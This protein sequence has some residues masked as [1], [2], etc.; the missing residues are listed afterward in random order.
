MKGYKGMNADM[1]CR[2]MQFEVG[3][4]YHVDGKI[5]VCHNG[6]HFCKNLSDV[7]GY[8]HRYLN[9]NRF[10]IVDVSGTIKTDGNKSAASDMEIIRELN[11]IE[12]NRVV[13][14]NGYGCGYGCDGNGY[15][16]GKGYGYDND[17]G[18]GNG[19]GCGNNGYGDGNG[20]GCG[21]DN[22]YDDNGYNGCGCG[23]YNGCDG[24]GCGNSNGRGYI[25]EILLFV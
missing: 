2:G 9:R 13:Y 25:K 1:T 23:C 17:Y 8:Y 16:C 4:K 12:I 20:Y 5:E 11:E 10:F 15:G 24:N 19:Y 6:L 21:Y 7:F 22:I 3:K 14:G 18:C